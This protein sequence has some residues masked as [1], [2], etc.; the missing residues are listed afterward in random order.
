MHDA[1]GKV[2]DDHLISTESNGDAEGYSFSL[3][4]V[5]PDSPK[6]YRPLF[7]IGK[8]ETL[9][10][11]L[12]VTH[13]FCDH[14]YLWPTAAALA[15]RLKAPW[16]LRSHNIESKRFRTLGKPWW[17]VMHLFE[18]R[19]MRAADAVFFIT[20]EEQAWARKHYKVDAA[21]A[22][23]APYGTPLAAPPAAGNS[24]AVLAASLDLDPAKPWLYFLGALGYSANSDAVRFLVDHVVPLLRARGAAVQILVAGK[25]LPPE[26][27]EAIGRTDGL[28]RYTG[29]VEDLDVFI[30]ACDVMLN[31]V[32]TGGGIKTKAVEAL[33]YNKMVVSTTSGAEGLDPLSCSPNLIICKD[34]DW[35]AFAA[36]TLLAA[37]RHPAIGSQFYERYNWDRIAE[38]VAGV[39]KDL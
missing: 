14:P 32:L 39:M 25:G 28:V 5:Y 15:K 34:R 3:H 19:G 33:A 18:G 10:R 6:H 23:L 16:A 8:I 7:G 31:P 22:F 29:F 37:K 20:P 27:Q 24:R 26:L 12:G 2:C 38:Y 36:E 11:E 1:L 35:T 17:P 9:A 13:I 21:K 4:K 30:N